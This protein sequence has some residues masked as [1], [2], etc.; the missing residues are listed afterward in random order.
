M[1][2]TTVYLPEGLKDELVRAS[3]SGRSEPELLR[4][5]VRSVV[6]AQG[7]ARPRI[8]LF[9]SDDGS[10]AERAAECLVGFGQR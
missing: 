6:E 2:R 5:G 1:V 4:D 3:G 8:P 10:L 9:T 7:T